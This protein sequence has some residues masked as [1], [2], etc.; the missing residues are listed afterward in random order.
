MQTEMLR[1]HICQQFPEFTCLCNFKKAPNLNFNHTQFHSCTLQ[2]MTSAWDLKIKNIF[3]ITIYVN[4]TWQTFVKS[5]LENT[6]IFL[7][8][9]FSK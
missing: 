3:T 8:T 1:T 5:V 9:V 6:V 4:E 2:A 7:H